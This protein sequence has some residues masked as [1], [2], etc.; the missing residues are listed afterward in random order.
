[1]RSWPLLLLTLLACDSPTPASEVSPTAPDGPLD[2]LVVA[3][4]DDVE[5][6]ISVVP[7]TSADGEVTWLT[8]PMVAD[9]GFDCGL[10]YHP[11]R[12]TRVELLGR[13]PNALGRAAR[14]CP[15]ERRHALHR[16]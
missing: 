13:R 11:L 5:S 2:T 1:V 8:N 12:R 3:W 7:Q 16:P 14:R 9:V 15:V 4:G 10:S 6:L